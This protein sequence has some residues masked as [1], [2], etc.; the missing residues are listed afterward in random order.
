[1][2]ESTRRQDLRR[3]SLAS[4]A[5]SAIE[6]YDFFI[7]GTAA[8]L[9]FPTVFFPTLSHVMATTASLATFASA[10]IARPLGSAVF[11]HFGDR[12]GRKQT[13]VITL[14]LMGV[15]TVGVG[16]T[17]SAASIGCAAPLLLVTLRLIQGFAVGGEWAGAA[18]MCAE[19]APPS[20][21]GYYGMFT[22]LGLGTALVLAN[23]AFL[24][25]FQVVDQ[26]SSSFFQWAWRIPFLFSAALI[27]VALYVRLHV[28]ETPA[29]TAATTPEEQSPPIATL[30]RR[31][32]GEVVL[33]AG[34]VICAPMLAFQTGT[35][36]TH[37]AADHLGYSMSLVLGVGVIGGICTAGFV[38]ASAILS[39]RYGRRF[40]LTIGLAL[41]VPWSF[42]VFPLIEVGSASTFGVVVA[43]TYAL[44]GFC[45]GPQAS[46]LPEIFPTQFRYSGSALSHTAGVI[47][48]GSLLP[49][50]SPV[51]LNYFG[52][53]LVALVMGSLAFVSLISV[54]LL[55]E[56]SGRA[57]TE[58]ETQLP[59]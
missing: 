12:I 7:Y 48:G 25:T 52:G 49:V 37:Y 9:V 30:M 6:F 43:T 51:L 56:T 53:W 54:S 8:A 59:R 5:G 15:A 22:Q 28:Q 27:A 40:I 31:Q 13:L 20:K 38:A 58:P 4:Y 57:L 39:D 14:A 11:G 24:V 18:L 36:F 3:I 35:F 47:I 33:A 21:R 10:F 29:F 2:A 19:H 32:R 55:P 1:M 41:A 34:A 17:P 46:F 50:L 45:M 23:L 44:V 26:T 42:A 16:L